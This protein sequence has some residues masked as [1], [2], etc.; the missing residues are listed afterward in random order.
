MARPRASPTPRHPAQLRRAVFGRFAW[1]RARPDD[2]D[3]PSRA[4]LL[5]RAL[6]HRLTWQQEY[7]AAQARADLSATTPAADAA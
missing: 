7:R 5:M 1:E 4:R 6:T 3:T 2:P